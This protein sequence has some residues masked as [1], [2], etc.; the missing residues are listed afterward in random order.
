MI[1]ALP[2]ATLGRARVEINEAGVNWHR[3]THGSARQEP[4]ETLER[5]R[6]AGELVADALAHVRKATELL[7]AYAGLIDGG[8]AGQPP[9]GGARD[10]ASAPAVL[11]RALGRDDLTSE[12]RSNLTRYEKK[13][14]AAATHV[15]IRQRPDGT[16]QFEAMVSGRVPGSYALYTKTVD[17]AGR[18]I[19]Y[20]KTTHTP[21]GSIAHTKDKMP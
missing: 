18:T 12:Q 17:G 13:L 8:A 14:P 5:I 9:S 3:V 20:T 16:I 6:I 1:A 7:S 15:V 11:A 4:T 10:S 21:D 2:A 19:A